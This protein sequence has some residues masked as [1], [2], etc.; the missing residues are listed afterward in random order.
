MHVINA[1][2]GRDLVIRYGDHT[3]LDRS[4]FSIPAGTITAIIGPNGSGKSTLLNA[5]A[6]LVDPAA[7][8]ID[9][10][11]R[12]GGSSRISYVLQTTKVNDSLPVSVREVV[13]MG[14]YAGLG[15]YG[16]LTGE[17]RQEV[18][19]AMERTGIT[20]LGSRQ[21]HELSGG[22]RQRVFVAQG[23]AQSHDLLL[24]DEPLTGI[25][26]T[27]AQAIDEAIHQERQRGCTVLLT[28]HD[29][30]EAQVA[31]HVVLLA[32]RVVA[33]GPPQ[34]VL[35]LENL[36]AAY[37]PAVLH[38]GEDGLF[39]DDAAHAPVDERRVHLQRSIHTESSQ[40]EAHPE[41]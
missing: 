13:T 6:G 32:G 21:L 7:G 5:I 35:T 14:R 37:G 19:A 16:W 4:T 8:T 41:T 29:L 28:T 25:D 30:S 33:S 23:M 22:Q 3:A 10:S 40:T 31:D 39:V 36:K 27:T 26:L 11:A 24:L 34:H 9:V 38:V 1:V 18:D 20:D 15:A 2:E 12:D 17:D